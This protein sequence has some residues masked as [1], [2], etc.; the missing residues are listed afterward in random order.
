MYIVTYVFMVLKVEFRKEVEEKFRELAMRKF[1][2]SK[3]SIKKASLEAITKWIKEQNP[4]MPKSKNPTKLIE[5]S[6]SHLNGKYTSVE[7]QHEASKLWIK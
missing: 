4:D 6:L 7:L 2:Y 5:G 3:G 1:G